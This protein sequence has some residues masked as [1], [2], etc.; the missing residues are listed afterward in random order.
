MKEWRIKQR[1]F[2]IAD[3]ASINWD[4]RWMDDFDKITNGISSVKI[5]DAYM[6]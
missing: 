1:L 3:L 5:N 2:P 6:S 4:K